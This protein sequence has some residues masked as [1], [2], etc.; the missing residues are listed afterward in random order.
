M[1]RLLFFAGV[2]DTLDLFIYE[3]K[4][5]LETMQ[6]ETMVFDVRDMQQSLKNL[7]QFVARPVEAAVTFNNLGFN[8]ELHPG[9][10]L[11]EELNIPCINILMDHPFCYHNALAAA[12]RNA[13]VLCTDRNHM[14]YVSR[15]YPKI[16][17]SGFL[18]HGGIE[19]CGVRKPVREQIGRAHV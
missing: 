9:V 8:M 10:N 16:P 17:V 12:P 15:F 3:L 6:Y 1:K 5:E 19:A 11:W 7:A 2:Y 18:P 4:R 13:V 14:A